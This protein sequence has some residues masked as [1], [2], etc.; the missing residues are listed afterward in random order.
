MSSIPRE[1]PFNVCNNNGFPV[2]AWDHTRNEASAE[3]D[4]RSPNDGTKERHLTKSVCPSN[5][6]KHSRV[7]ISS[8]SYKMYLNRPNFDS[9]VPGTRIQ[10]FSIYSNRAYRTCVPSKCM[11]KLSCLVLSK[12]RDYL[13]TS[14]LTRRANPPL[15]P[16]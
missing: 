3:P 6:N 8:C 15:S 5:V 14:K 13:N 9:F 7:Y 11:S 2:P 12:G 16:V 10:Q 4:N 1:W